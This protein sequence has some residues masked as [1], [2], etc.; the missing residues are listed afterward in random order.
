M[1]QEERA[2]DLDDAYDPQGTRAEHELL[3][4][5]GVVASLEALAT[6]SARTEWEALDDRASRLL[7]QLQSVALA[8]LGVDAADDR[9]RILSAKVD[10]LIARRELARK[11]AAGT[12]SS[13]APALA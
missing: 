11:R 1:A 4:A 9:A 3:A 10:E 5:A 12:E 13:P 7:G 6:Q 2:W 8:Q